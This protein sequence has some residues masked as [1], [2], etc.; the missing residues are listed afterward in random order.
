[1][2]RRN[3]T[4]RIEWR[5]PGLSAPSVMTVK[6]AGEGAPWVG[7][8]CPT[9]SPQTPLVEPWGGQYSLEGAALVGVICPPLSPQTPLVE[10]WGGP[11]RGQ[12]WVGIICPPLLPRTS[13]VD[14]KGGPQRGQLW[15]GV[16]FPSPPW[17]G[18]P[19]PC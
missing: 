2:R 15:M 6:R 9:L 4:V 13:L 19:W 17:R 14:P 10:P 16:V 18:T 5:S 12:P 8:I 1:M 3:D 7:V 11:Q